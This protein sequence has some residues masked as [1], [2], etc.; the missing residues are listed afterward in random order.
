MP[1]GSNSL[2]PRYGAW[3][4]ILE[5]LQAFTVFSSVWFRATVALLALS[6]VA[7]SASRTRRVWE[8][9]RRPTRSLGAVAG[10]RLP[11][12]ATFITALGPAAALE[13]VG[14]ALG[15][16]IFRIGIDEGAASL[17]LVAV[18]FR[19]APFA[20][21]VIH[22]SI[23]VILVGAVVG[24]AFGFHESRVSVPI[25][26][27]VEVGHDTGLTLLATAFTDRYYPDGS[28]RDY[29]SHLV[30]THAGTPAAE[31]DVRVNEPLR[32]GDISVYQSYFGAAASMRIVDSEGA[33]IFGAIVPLE[34]VTADGSHV[35]GRI[36]LA[37]RGTTVYVIAPASGRLD[38]AILP[39]QMEI[40]VV[41]PRDPADARVQILSQG[42]PT[43]VEGLTVTFVREARYTGLI[44]ARDPGRPF[45]WG[46]AALLVVAS[47]A[48]FTLRERRAWA[49]A[50]PTSAGS[51]IR[52]AMTQRRPSSGDLAA[53]E[54]LTAEIKAAM[55]VRQRETKKGDPDAEVV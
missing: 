55:D 41:G 7:C 28:P 8:R 47:L 9:A 39:G 31:G 49:S 42:I 35:V 5:R 46:G 11:L 27:S 53:F 37:D 32:Y 30:L 24:A 45:V 33:A 48:A 18:R 20:S 12:Q 54:R 1:R 3:T 38:P 25:G 16:R 21:V 22:L 29:A 43:I 44:V 51:E 15:R 36:A 23:V 2:R 40:R 13:Q 6:L 19:W 26:T 17:D 52:L 10:E 14:L 34:L 50:R 4:T